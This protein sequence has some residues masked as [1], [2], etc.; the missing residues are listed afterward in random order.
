[1]DIFDVDQLRSGLPDAP[2]AYREFLRAP[3][4]SVGLY[5]LTAG[6]ADPQR[7][8]GEDEVYVVIEGRATLDVE[9]RSSTVGP[10]S[11][12]FVAA[13]ADHRFRNV[14][15]DLVTVVLFAPQESGGEAGEEE[16]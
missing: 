6:S 11:V 14:E 10:G 12:A 8:H 7:P 15:E 5:R 3:T 1:M 4:M 16:E 2:A 9:G 13:A